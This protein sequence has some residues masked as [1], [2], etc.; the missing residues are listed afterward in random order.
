MRRR[1]DDLKAAFID[2]AIIQENLQ[3]K[4]LKRKPCLQEC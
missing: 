2:F 4:L 1:V 3:Q